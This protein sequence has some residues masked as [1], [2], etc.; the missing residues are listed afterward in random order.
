MYMILWVTDNS[1]LM[2]NELRMNRLL[3]SP[4][5]S[6]RLIRQLFITTETTPNPNALK[7]VPGQ[8]VLGEGKTYDFPGKVISL[9][10]LPFTMFTF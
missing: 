3:R 9:F 5:Y 8:T 10:G 2:L 6:N 4:A 1:Y 7:F